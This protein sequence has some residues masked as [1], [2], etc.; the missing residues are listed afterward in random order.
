MR[1]QLLTIIAT[2]ITTL[3]MAGGI[4]TNT[5]QSAS[6]VRMPAQDATL[7]IDAAYYNPAGLAFIADGFYVSVNNQ[8]ITQTRE[9]TSTFPGMNRT[10]FEG[11]VTAPLFPGLYMVFKK[12]RVAFSLGINPIGGGGSAMFEN[13]L[14]SF[15]QQVAVL[16]PSLTAAGINTTAYEFSS[17]FEGRSLMW[18]L[19]A[20]GSYAINDM[21][22]FSVGIRY[23][24]AQNFYTGYMKDIR[25]NP[26]HPLNPAGAGQMTSAPEFFGI[27]STAATNAAN[28]LTPLVTGGG[29][30]LT[31]NQAVTLSYLTPAQATQLA[32]GLGVA[33]YT[34]YP[35]T[36]SQIQ[37]A[38]Q[39]NA[40]TMAAYSA[41]TSDKEVD[42]E[43]NGYGL[44]PIIGVNVKVNDRLNIGF[45][46][47]HKASLNV[48]NKTK[49]DDAKLYPDG[50]SYPN[51]MPTTLS[52]GVSYKATDKLG[53]SAG[54]HY[55][56]DKTA[57][58]GKVESRDANGFPTFYENKEVI[59]NNFLEIALGFEYELNDKILLS[60]G[61]LRTQSGVNMKYQSDLSHSLST[62]T[63]GLGGRYKVSD[64]IG[65]NVGFMKSFYLMKTKPFDIPVVYDETYKRSA[66]VFALGVDLKF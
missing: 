27:L 45:K 48:K 64:K 59:D 9:I 22:S 65:V 60:A 42:V 3:V 6:Y 7:G 15:E 21:I 32:A 25:I 57:A 43:Q 17:E 13:G 44:A 2:G 12:E 16:P 53:I 33:D 37:T 52:L 5:N 23:V 41:M 49:K 62:N 11:G 63:V 20:N 55:Y 34:T 56:F 18:G 36:I 26:M 61:Y 38:Y 28:S 35:A 30:G 50:V 10:K 19:Q 8:Y 40:A 58:Y 31:L 14:P 47:E 4:V 54:A 29:G 24:I 1:K 51:D 66:T 39:T 46:Y